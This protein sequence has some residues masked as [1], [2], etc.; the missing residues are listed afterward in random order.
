MFSAAEVEV[1]G[2]LIHVSDHEVSAGTVDQRLL[3]VI[4]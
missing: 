2:S 1:G 4:L 3:K